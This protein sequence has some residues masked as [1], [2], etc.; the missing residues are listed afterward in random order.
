M[1]N[2]ENKMTEHESV[3]T[4]AQ[5]LVHGARNADYGHPLDDFTRTAGMWSAILGVHITAKQVGL[6]M[7]AVKL[8]RECN[9]AKRDNL[10]DLAGYAETVEWLKDEENKRRERQGLVDLA[11]PARTRKPRKVV[12]VAAPSE[13]LDNMV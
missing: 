2:E 7:I 5:K 6:C 9:K 10:V 1:T 4:E 8:S 12:E 13:D 3:L 11:T